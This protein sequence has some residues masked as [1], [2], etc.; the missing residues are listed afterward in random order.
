ML[1]KEL[2]TTSII[3]TPPALLI[4]EK[5]APKE[6]RIGIVGHLMYPGCTVIGNTFPYITYFQR[7]GNVKII[8]PN[9]ELMEND[10][11]LLVLPGGPDVDAT[12]YLGKKDKV[13][14]ANQKPDPMREWFDL[15]MLPQ[16]IDARIPV[17]GICRGHQTLAVHFGAQLIQDLGRSHDSNADNDRRELIQS[18]AFYNTETTNNKLLFVPEN[19]QMR[20]NIN[21][22]HHQAVKTCPD[23]AEVIGWTVEEYV[24]SK[25]DKK[26]CYMSS[27]KYPTTA[28]PEFKEGN[29]HHIIEALMYKDY[30]IASVQWH[31]LR[32]LSSVN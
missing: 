10:I 3:E 21:S 6:I 4:A 17:L 5:E 2:P 18:L 14:F 24:A 25:G 7:F 8:L 29:P 32:G 22:M 1:Q 11:D 19:N 12:R 20:I 13:S 9:S 26:G 30:P 28:L 27:S 16:Y 15:N 31:P 23:N